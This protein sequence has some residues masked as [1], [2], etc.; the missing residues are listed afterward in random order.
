MSNEEISNLA[1]EL[2]KSDKEVQEK[3]DQDLINEN[4]LT[5]K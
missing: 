4:E 1:E 2:N 5:E 3:Y